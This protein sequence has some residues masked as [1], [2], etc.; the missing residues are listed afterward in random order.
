MNITVIGTGYVGL[1]QGVCLAELGNTVYC[2]DIDATKVEK[3]NNGISPIYEPGIEELITHNLKEHR[4]FFTTSIADGLKN[5]D[6]VFIAVGTPS[7]PD[8]TADLRYVQAAAEDIGKNLHEPVAVVTKSSVPIGTSHMVRETIAKHYQGDFEVLSNPEF[9]KEGTAIADFMKPDRVVI[10]GSDNS[11]AVHLVARLYEVLGAPILIT[12]SETAEMIKYASNSYLATQISF[13]NSIA[14]ICEKVG[15]DVTEVAKGMKLDSRIGS[16]AFLQ[17][18]LGYGGSCFPKDVDATIQ[19]GLKYDVHF[20]LLEA[21]RDTNQLQRTH[22]M[23]KIKAAEGTLKG[24]II[25]LWGVAFKPLTDDIRQAPSIDIAKW[26][27]EEGATLNIFDHVAQQNFQK[28]FPAHAPITF[29]ADALEAATKSDALIIIT[30]WNEFKQ[31]NFADLLKHMATPTIYDGR[32]IYSKEDM[33]TME[34]LGISYTS[35]GR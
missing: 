5:C 20:T 1:V 22:F 16:R 12:N 4:L 35:I 26:L 23:E 25:T 6:I 11:P 14:Q 34:E 33:K 9:L 30:E 21:T 13:I 10:G 17:A 15:A 31:I 7:N 3:L 29:F 19:M 18:G 28:L 8:G 32:N 24:K 2:V 27:I